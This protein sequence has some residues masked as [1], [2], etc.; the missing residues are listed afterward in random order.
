MEITTRTE[1]F[2]R[3]VMTLGDDERKTLPINQDKA[4]V[5]DA[6]FTDGTI[7]LHLTRKILQHFAQDMW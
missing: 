7:Q 1:E 2:Y 4:L 3:N 5:G 6:S